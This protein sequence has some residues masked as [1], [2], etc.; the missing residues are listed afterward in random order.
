M[1]DMCI[2]IAGNGATHPYGVRFLMVIYEVLSS[3]SMHLI[4]TNIEGYDFQ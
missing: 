2:A 4:T 3:N 1:S